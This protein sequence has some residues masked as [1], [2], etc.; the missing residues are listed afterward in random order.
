EGEGGGGGCEVRGGERGRV[1]GRWDR[2]RL[3]QVVLNL[4]SN[5]MKY[6]A[7]EPIDIDITLEPGTGRARLTVRD[8]GIGIAPEALA[9]IFDRFERAVSSRHYGG[10]GLG[11]YI[12]RLIL[13]AL[14]GTV[15]VESM[16]GAGALFTVELPVAGPAV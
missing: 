5:A 15:R 7:G 10:L 2:L 11:P 8:H 14:G 16:L 3:E 12:R 13:G 1:G 4:L 9:Q 6:G